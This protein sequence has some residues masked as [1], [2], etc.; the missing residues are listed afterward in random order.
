M[1]P[2]RGHRA[3]CQELTGGGI[4]HLSELNTL[5]GFAALCSFP[6]GA[7]LQGSG[8]GRLAWKLEVIQTG[9]KWW[10]VLKIV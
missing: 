9:S 1:L 8:N 2:G 5:R 10:V 3:V 6:V 4:R 7:G